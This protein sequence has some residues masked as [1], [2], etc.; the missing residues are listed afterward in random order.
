MR[1]KVYINKSQLEHLDQTKI[2]VKCS[3]N[4]CCANEPSEKTYLGGTEVALLLG[5]LAVGIGL[6]AFLAPET[7][8]IVLMLV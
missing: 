1:A 2:E 3:E 4:Q 6:Q 8:P 5:L 7:I